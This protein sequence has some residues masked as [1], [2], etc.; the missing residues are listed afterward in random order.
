M[1]SLASPVPLADLCQ[2][3]Q[4]SDKSLKKSFL[5]ARAI[6]LQNIHPRVVP[7][8]PWGPLKPGGTQRWRIYSG[9]NSVLAPAACWIPL[10]GCTSLTTVISI[11]DLHK[12]SKCL[13]HHLLFNHSKH[14]IS[15][16]AFLELSV[17]RGLGSTPPPGRAGCIPPIPTPVLG[18]E[19]L[20]GSSSAAPIWLLA[21]QQG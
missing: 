6:K 21:T 9:T 13:C 2:R 18:S 14:C 12:T 1:R 20:L 19:M 11:K 3:E 7:E 17:L 16:T 8:G 10:I 5:I 15:C 4:R